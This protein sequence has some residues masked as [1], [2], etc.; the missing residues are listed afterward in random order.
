MPAD[1]ADL[2]ARIERAVLTADFGRLEEIRLQ[3]G[4]PTGGDAPDRLY[5]IAYV[6]WR[7]TQLVQPKQRKA[8]SQEAERALQILLQERPGDAEALALL[9]SA[10]GARITGFWSG[11]RLGKSASRALNQAAALAPDNPRI[12]LQ[13][14]ISSYF[15]PKTFGGGIDRAEAIVRHSLELFQRQSDDTPWP[16]WGHVDAYAWLGQVLAKKGDVAGARDAYQ[17]GLALEPDH[18][19]ISEVLLPQLDS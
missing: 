9:G 13:Q 14:G 19:W 3:L 1:Q 16:N 10:Y 8:Y 17:K 2:V 6:N 7:L 15:S 12:A 4:D 5:T 11:I 18:R